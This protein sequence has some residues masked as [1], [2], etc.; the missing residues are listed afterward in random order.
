MLGF[1]TSTQPRGCNSLLQ[2][3]EKAAIIHRLRPKT[4]QYYNEF[5]RCPDCDRIYW[6]GSHFQRMEQFI[7]RVLREDLS[8]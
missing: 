8:G 4:R 1:I 5:R 3:V 2:P 7:E 6:P